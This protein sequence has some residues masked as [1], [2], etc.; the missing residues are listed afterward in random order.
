MV[1][2]GLDPA[3]EAVAE[4]PSLAVVEEEVGVPAAPSVIVRPK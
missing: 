1:V 3:V 2:E 4:D